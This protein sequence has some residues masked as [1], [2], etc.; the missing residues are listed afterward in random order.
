LLPLPPTTGF[1]ASAVHEKAAWYTSSV[2]RNRQSRVTD[3]RD[4]RLYSGPVV[5]VII[6]VVKATQ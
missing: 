5:I 1:S 3:Q 6:V 4:P 2:Q